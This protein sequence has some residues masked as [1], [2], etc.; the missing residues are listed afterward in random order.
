MQQDDI[1]KKCEELL[2]QLGI[3][4]FVIFGWK[5]SDTEFGM[6]QAYR[7]VPVPAAI[8][9]LSWALNDLVAKTL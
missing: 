1:Q 7:E 8:K 5:K 4:G 2:T 9:G 6:V 3:P